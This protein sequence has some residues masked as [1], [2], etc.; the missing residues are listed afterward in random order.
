MN[1]TTSSTSSVYFT[2]SFL[3]S[4]FLIFSDAPS[5]IYKNTDKILFE[6]ITVDFTVM[7]KETEVVSVEVKPY[8]TLESLMELDKVR[9]AEVSKKKLHKRMVTSKTVKEFSTF[10]ATAVGKHNCSIIHLT[11]ASSV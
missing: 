6:T 2:T 8:N 4:F 3:T 10:G 9:I 5:V 7:Y 11:V 1:I